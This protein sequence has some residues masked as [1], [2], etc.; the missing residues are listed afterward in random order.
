MNSMNKGIGI[1]LVE[2]EDI[3]SRLSEAFIERIL[4]K[5]E[6]AYFITITHPQRKLEYLAGR[7]AA[8]E[9]YTKAYGEFDERLSFYQ[10]EVLRK[11]NG[12]PYIESTYSE[13]DDVYVSISHTKHYAIAMVMIEKKT[14]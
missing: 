1:D 10:V 2:I 14:K 9:A 5:R 6:Y 3:K 13:D 8:K 11:E 4:S 7:F 12:V